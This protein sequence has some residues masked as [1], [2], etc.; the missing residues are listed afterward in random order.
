LLTTDRLLLRRPTP[1]DV[2][3]RHH[4]EGWERNGIGKF[5]VVRLEDG[6]VV[7]RVGVQLLD[8][9][10]WEPAAGGAGQAEL[11]WSL[12]A[13][14]WGHGYA[15]EAAAAV[16]DWYPTPDRLV[17]LIQPHNAR[18]QAVA[19]RLGAEPAETIV[20][21]DGPHV[22]WVHPSAKIGGR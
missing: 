14:H 15:T 13:A 22:A 3:M 2:D 12:R 9:V 18:S 7:G 17:S 8:P 5:V 16:R 6:I 21:D 10:T 1:D 20:L 11:G 4:L 19:R